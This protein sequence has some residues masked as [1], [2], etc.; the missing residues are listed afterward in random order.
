MTIAKRLVLLLGVPLAVLVVLGVFAVLQLARIE[1]RSRLL[2]AGAFADRILET[3]T[4]WTKRAPTE[5][6]DD[7]ITLLVIRSTREAS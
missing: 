1:S 3:V 7:D 2:S 4:G 5:G 6:T